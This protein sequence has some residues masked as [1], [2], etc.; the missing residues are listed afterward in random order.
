MPK[1]SRSP[2]PVTDTEP[3]NLYSVTTV[4]KCPPR[5]ADAR[6]Q[7]TPGVL[8][9]DNTRRGTETTPWPVTAP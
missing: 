7:R 3:A 6:H 9:F 1:D 5:L 2:T 8:S 4:Q